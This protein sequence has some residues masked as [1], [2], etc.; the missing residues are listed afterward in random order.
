MNDFSVMERK[1][2]IEILI[3]FPCV[4]SL[5]VLYKILTAHA[6]YLCHSKNSSIVQHKWPPD[7]AGCKIIFKIIYAIFDV[8]PQE[9]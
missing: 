3:G 7:T 6:R 4:L 2:K 8:F 5:L 9:N 1:N